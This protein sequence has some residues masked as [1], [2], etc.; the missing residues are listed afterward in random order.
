MRVLQIDFADPSFPLS[1]VEKDDPKLPSSEWALCRVI[2]G[3][4]C[5][6]DTQLFENPT[7]NPLMT[8]FVGL[9]M[10]MGHEIGAVV[11]DPGA[12]FP[13][14]AGTRI[15]VDPVIACE[16]RGIDPKCE[17]C[18]KGLPS[19]CTN[20]ASRRFTPGFALGYTTGLGSGW[21]DVVAVHRSMAYPVPEEVPDA[22]TSLAEPL[23]VSVHGV[24]GAPPDQG[25]Y[26]LVVGCGIIGI[27]AIAALRYLFPEVFVVAVARYS[28]QAAV[29]EEVGANAVVMGRSQEGTPR[30][31][32]EVFEELAQLV[33]GRLVSSGGEAMLAGGFDY[34][35]EAAGSESSLT[36]ALRAAAPRATVLMLGVMGRANVDLTTLW[37]KELRVAG[38]FCHG[39]HRIAGQN[40]ASIEIALE[41]LANQRLT[42]KQVVSATFP[43][44]EYREALATAMDHKTTGS[45][46]VVFDPSQ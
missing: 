26:A 28:H 13:Y 34:V 29:A 8:R 42:A 41:M 7:P 30:P 46:K 33:E 17:Q 38:S 2:R 21:S 36:M 4:I 14:P 20:L 40:A 27:T 44:E 37:L 19:C 12:D 1:L 5:G 10:E 43:L 18:S 11:E 24:L 35:I 32:Y 23:S 22:A 31:E 15:A 3:G 39:S 16:A 9:P 45:I 6:S 25:G